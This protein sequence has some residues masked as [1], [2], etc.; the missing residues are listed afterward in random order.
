MGIP[1]TG[2]NFLIPPSFTTITNIII[3]R[4]REREREREGERGERERERERERELKL[5]GLKLEIP[6]N[7]KGSLFKDVC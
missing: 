6:E 4:E 2:I 3:G 5:C 7:V 1:N